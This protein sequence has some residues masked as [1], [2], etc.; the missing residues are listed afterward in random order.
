MRSSPGS[1]RLSFLLP[2]GTAAAPGAY[3]NWVQGCGVEI[4]L[5]RAIITGP[6]RESVLEQAA[7]VV[8]VICQGKTELAID[9]VLEA[10]P[11]GSG[12][13]GWTIIVGADIA[14]AP[15]GLGVTFP[16]RA[17]A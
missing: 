17:V 16:E 15:T 8:R 1:Y 12:R 7:R 6:S 2:A 9:A 13:D 3:S 10:P 14:F 4:D 11:P 5:V